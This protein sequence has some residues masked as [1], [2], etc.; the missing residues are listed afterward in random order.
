[1]YSFWHQACFSRRYRLF[2]SLKHFGE[3]CGFRC[4]RCATRAVRERITSVHA[5]QERVHPCMS[6]TAL[7]RN[8]P[9]VPHRAR[10]VVRVFRTAVLRRVDCAFSGVRDTR[11]TAWRLPR[12]GRPHA[13]HACVRCVGVFSAS[14]QC[15]A[16][17][18]S[19]ELPHASRARVA[20]AAS[21]ADFGA[22]PRVFRLLCWPC[23]EISLVR[24]L[25][26][27]VPRARASSRHSQ[28]R[29]LANSAPSPLSA[30]I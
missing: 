24:C 12:H 8:A 26:C 22:L 5:C 1:M 4:A 20:P 25:I 29:T 7:S 13:P 16:V 10:R 23:F 27:A 19:S 28:H 6:D 17:A 9:V 18:F 21:A 30:V 14:R 3:A 15:F 2:E 11:S